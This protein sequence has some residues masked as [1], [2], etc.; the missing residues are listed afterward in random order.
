[1]NQT[2]IFWPMLAQVVLVYVVYGVLAK[3]RFGP[4]FSGTVK[5]REF[6]HR[7][8][9]PA[10]SATASNNLMNQFELPVLFFGLCLSFYVT[11]GVNRLAVTLAWLFVL[12]RCIHAAVHLTR[13]HVGL[14]SALFATGFVVLGIGW[15]LFAMQ[16]GRLI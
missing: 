5:A 14:R 7:G 4:L 3:R 10:G 2:A 16:M 13:N 8:V 15:I 1:M 9:E 6:R 11:N 12:S